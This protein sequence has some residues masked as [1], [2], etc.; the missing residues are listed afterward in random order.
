MYY[1]YY[2]YKILICY[3]NLNYT[4]T[5]ILVIEISIYI[6]ICVCNYS[7]IKSL[8]RIQNFEGIKIGKLLTSTYV[9]LHYIIMN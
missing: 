2:I 5:Q 6:Y 8:I 1:N 7:I 9:H 3:F 4:M